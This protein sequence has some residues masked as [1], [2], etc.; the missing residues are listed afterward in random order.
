MEK[1]MVKNKVIE[2]LR[3]SKWEWVDKDQIH[4]GIWGFNQWERDK[5]LATMEAIRELREEK[6]LFPA[7]ITGIIT[8]P[9]N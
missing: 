3:N 7:E 1:E 5:I 2:I 6:R 9:I 4:V 8:L